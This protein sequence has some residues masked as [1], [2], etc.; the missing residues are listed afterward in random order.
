MGSSSS[1][2]AQARQYKT[3][4]WQAVCPPQLRHGFCCTCNVPS[5]AAV[6]GVQLQVVIRAVCAADLQASHLEGVCI[7]AAL[8]CVFEPTTQRLLAV[9]PA[10]VVAAACV[11]MSLLHRFR[12]VL[13]DN[14]IK[15]AGQQFPICSCCCTA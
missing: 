5:A 6:Q 3:D 13:Q 10:N 8:V 2:G 14:M 15:V 4:D 11:L 9:G 7:E 12:Q 1:D